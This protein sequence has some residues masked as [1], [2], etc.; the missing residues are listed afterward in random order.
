[1]F[2]GL[3]FTGPVIN[4]K[5]RRSLDV[6][7]QFQVVQGRVPENV[8]P[9]GIGIVHHKLRFLLAKPIAFVAFDDDS[10][11]FD[12][13]WINNEDLVDKHLKFEW[14]EGGRVAMERNKN[15]NPEN[16]VILGRR[17]SMPVATESETGPIRV[18]TVVEQGTRVE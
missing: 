12:Y 14:E 1:M 10:A 9:V 11:D 13:F 17:F 18:G 7:D 6:S 4:A 16:V 2:V 3:L 8:K 15:G 5:D